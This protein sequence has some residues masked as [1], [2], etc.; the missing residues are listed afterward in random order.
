ME[1]KLKQIMSKIFEIELSKIK[2]TSSPNEIS[3]WDSLHH[4]MLIVEL[5]KAFNI[6]FSDDELISLADFK[7]ICKTISK[8]IKK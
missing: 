3:K 2:T 1:D 4:L 5:E 7:S 8:K 6:K